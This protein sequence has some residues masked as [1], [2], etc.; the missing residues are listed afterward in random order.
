[1]L[2]LDIVFFRGD[3]VPAEPPSRPRSRGP[4]A[5]LRSGGSPASLA[6]PV[7]C[8]AATRT[9]AGADGSGIRRPRQVRDARLSSNIADGFPRGAVDFARLLTYSASCLSET[10][11]WLNDVILRGH[12]NPD[13]LETATVLVK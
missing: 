13:D 1:M 8:R 11:N 2:I 12:W 7:P 6:R 3:C 10:E 4:C 9:S 5:P